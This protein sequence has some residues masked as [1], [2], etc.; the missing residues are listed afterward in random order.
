MTWTTHYPEHAP[1]P[2]FHQGN[3]SLGITFDSEKAVGHLEK[4]FRPYQANLQDR[5]RCHRS[6]MLLQQCN[7]HRHMEHNGFRR[8]HGATRLCLFQGPN[9]Y[10][11]PFRASLPGT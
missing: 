9:S 10:P 5:L 8:D 3:N 1:K 6:R 2:H 4:V 7:D 11:T